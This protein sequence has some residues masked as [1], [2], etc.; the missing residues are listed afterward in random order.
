MA[1]MSQY[2]KMGEKARTAMASASGTNLAGYN[3]QLDATKMFFDPALAVSFAR[4]GD[5]QATMK[6]VAEFSHTHGL[7]GEGAKNASFIGIEY[8]GGKVVGSKR[9]VKLRFDDTYMGMAADGKL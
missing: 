3:A 1:I 6:A 5:V 9:N 2:G 4:S 7:L 8:P